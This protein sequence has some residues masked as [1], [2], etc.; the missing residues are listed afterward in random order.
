MKTQ[1]EID[2][3]ARD[4]LTSLFMRTEPLDKAFKDW[5]E[6]HYWH[7]AG[8]AESLALLSMALM[9]CVSGAQDMQRAAIRI[10]AGFLAARDGMGKD[11]SIEQAIALLEATT[12]QMQNQSAQAH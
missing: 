8:T 6:G 3:D 1:A 2:A 9:R 4:L 7:K 10:L 12:A 5:I 11:E